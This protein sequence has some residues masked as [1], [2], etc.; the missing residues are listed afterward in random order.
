MHEGLWDIDVPLAVNR[1]TADIAVKPR[2]GAGTISITSMS[3]AG[4]G[5][6]SNPLH[7]QETAGDLLDSGQSGAW[8]ESN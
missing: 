3:V 6:D 1:H 5:E 7:V 2:L 8:A 4:R